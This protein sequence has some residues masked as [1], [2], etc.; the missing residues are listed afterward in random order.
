MASD[1]EGDRRI[2]LK[3]TSIKYGAECAPD[4]AAPEQDLVANSSTR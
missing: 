4:S 1:L 3:F 2:I